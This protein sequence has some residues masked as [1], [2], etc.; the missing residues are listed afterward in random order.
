MR[1]VASNNINAGDRHIYTAPF[2]G[3]ISYKIYVQNA[4]PMVDLDIYILDGNGNVLA[5]DN[6]YASDAGCM[7]T[8]AWTDEYVIAVVCASGSTTYHLYIG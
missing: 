6:S 4:L 1:H 2:R 5:S 3:G 8:P 7:F